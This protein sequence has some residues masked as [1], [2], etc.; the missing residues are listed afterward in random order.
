M[1]D[2]PAAAPIDPLDLESQVCFAVA[3]ASREII[4]AYRPV[5]EELGL[6]H[7]QYLVML[8][9]WQH[10]EVSNSQLADLLGLD[11]GTATP[12]VQRLI[13]A[14]LVRKTRP[15]GG[16]SVLITA[17]AAGQALRERAEHVPTVMVR[18]LGMDLPELE[19]MRAMMHRLIGAS[20]RAEAVTDAERD[21]LAGR[22]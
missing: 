2:L 15:G 10:G 4:A 3:R 13:A 1:S 19:A 18:R 8:A 5:L 17:T 11:P 20:L 6:T 14:G 9:L 12:L 16:R 22:A 7:P 21:R